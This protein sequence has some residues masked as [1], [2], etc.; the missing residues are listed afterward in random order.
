MSKLL[1]KLNVSVIDYNNERHIVWKEY[2]NKFFL[3][4]RDRYLG[5]AEIVINKQGK[6]K[7]VYYEQGRFLQGCHDYEMRNA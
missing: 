3:R 1:Y 6:R 4:H 2:D 7:V 5:P